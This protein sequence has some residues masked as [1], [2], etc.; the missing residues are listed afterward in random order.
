MTASL[1][2]DLPKLVHLKPSLALGLTTML[3]VATTAAHAQKVAPAPAPT[4]AST[5]LQG[6]SLPLADVLVAAKGYPNLVTQI[7]LRLLSAGVAK[8]KV[9][10]TAQRFPNTWAALGGARVAPYVCPI[11]KRTVTIT[12][13]PTYYDKAGYKLKPTDPALPTKATKVVEGRMKW[14]WK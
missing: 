5:A 2:A 8:D 9:T 12:A 4:P 3:L 13:E 14:S 1:E 10:C 11:G 7:R 6:G